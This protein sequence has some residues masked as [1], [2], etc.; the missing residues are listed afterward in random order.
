MVNV[1]KQ[2]PAALFKAVNKKNEEKDHPY[3]SFGN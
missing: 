3:L 2:F 1:R